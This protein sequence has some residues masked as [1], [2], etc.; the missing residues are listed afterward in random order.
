MDCAMITNKTKLKNNLINFEN[1]TAMI[2][3]FYLLYADKMQKIEINSK[4]YIGSSNYQD[5]KFHANRI[6]LSSAIL[7]HFAFNEQLSPERTDL[8]V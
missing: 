2:E 4:K 6:E 8:L 3:K 7:S 1:K 5:I